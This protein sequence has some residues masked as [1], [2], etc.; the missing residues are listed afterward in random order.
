M[1]EYKAD[2]GYYYNAVQRWYYDFKSKMYYGGDPLAWTADPSLPRDAR[3]EVM[4]QP[5]QPGTNRPAL[6]AAMPAAAA[7]SRPAAAAAVRPGMR[8]TPAHPL[9]GLGGYQ[10]PKDGRIGGAKGVGAAHAQQPAADSSKV[11]GAACLGAA[12]G[13]AVPKD[14]ALA[15]KSGTKNVYAA[16]FICESM[17]EH[18]G[19]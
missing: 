16:V 9:A 7:S 8:A 13:E 5:Q 6:G 15:A 17:S 4:S 10:M 11:S 12:G 19:G 18:A 1:Q 3:Y 2:C 14:C